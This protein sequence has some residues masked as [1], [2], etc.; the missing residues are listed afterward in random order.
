MSSSI[1]RKWMALMHCWSRLSK[2]DSVNDITTMKSYKPMSQRQ[3]AHHVLWS[4]GFLG[5]I[6]YHKMCEDMEAK[7]SK[8]TSRFRIP[9][10][11]YPPP[12]S[13]YLNSLFNPVSPT[14][15]L[16]VAFWPSAIPVIYVF[17]CLYTYLFI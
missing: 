3:M 9:R 4:Q 14:A 13:V 2:P 16:S 8:I 5:H 7:N 17:A 11:P 10:A 1:I 12:P 6:S 15:V